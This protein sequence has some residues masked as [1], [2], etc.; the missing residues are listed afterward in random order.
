MTQPS[1][2]PDRND[3]VVLLFILLLAAVLRTAGLNAPLWYD[4][5]WTVDTHIRLPWGEMMRDYSMNHHYFFSL[6]AKLVSQIFGEQAWAYRFPAVVFGVGLVGAIWWLARDVA[7]TK[8]AH[9]SALLVALSYHQ[10]WFSQNARGYTE[11]AFWS[12]LGFVLF[13]RGIR[14]P[15]FGTWIAFGLT[16]AAAVFTHLTGVFFFVALGLVWLM[17]L[18]TGLGRGELTRNWVVRPLVGVAFALVLILLAYLPILP[19]IAGTMGEIAGTSAAD[20]MQEFQNPLWTIVEGVRTTIG[21]IN[22]GPMMLIVIIGGLIAIIC[23]VI[24][25][26]SAQPLFFPSIVAHIGVTLAILLTFDM[27]IWPRFFFVDIGPTII[28]VVIGCQIAA[29]LAARVFGRPALGRSLF[30]LGIFLMIGLSLFL[31][32][33]NYVAPKQNLAG[34][35]AFAEDIREPSE[36]VYAINP[37]GPIFASHFEANW[38]TI[39]S[40]EEYAEAMVKPGP[41]LLVVLFPNR[42]FRTIP[43]LERD[44]GEA[45][46]FIKGF[47]GTLGDGAILVYRRS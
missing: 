22:V 21:N 38:T 8:V 40:P 27:R 12:T 9:V 3:V 32:Q 36:R 17:S 30:V 28:L 42:M 25:A 6:Q 14:H 13:L 16:A 46:E 35:F 41:V 43:A 44:T 33:R 34:A 29:S 10:V 5:I 4:E 18:T 24:G 19:S 23:G 45:L 31:V 37:G 20:P 47:P 2:A 11:L 26:H 7:S 1:S 39:D 15:T